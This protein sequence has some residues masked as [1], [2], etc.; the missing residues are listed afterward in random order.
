MEKALRHFQVAMP[1]SENSSIDTTTARGASSGLTG[2]HIGENGKIARSMAWALKH[3]LMA[4]PI[5]DNSS[6]VIITGL[7]SLDGTWDTYMKVPLKITKDMD[8]AS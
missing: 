7:A 1:M 5:L 2:I 8:K 4:P 6:T 3:F